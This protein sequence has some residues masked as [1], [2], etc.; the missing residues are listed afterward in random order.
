MRFADNVVSESEQ[1][2]WVEKRHR[3]EKHLADSKAGLWSDICAAMTDA[4]T[5][6]ASMHLSG[7]TKI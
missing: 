2:D 3:A 1:L 7:S 6:F 4:S 5:V